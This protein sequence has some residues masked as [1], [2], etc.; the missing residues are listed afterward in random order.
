MSNSLEM[1]FSVIN[2]LVR[3]KLNRELQNIGLSEN[4]F[5]ILL[6]VCKHQGI[7]QK[8]LNNSIFRSHSIVNKRPSKLSDLGYLT[9]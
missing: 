2:R 9:I 4:N 6:T 8:D 1:M 5:M 7:S 3:L